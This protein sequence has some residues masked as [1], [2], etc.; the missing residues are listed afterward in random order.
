MF[1]HTFGCSRQVCTA[2]GR[3]LR[4][5]PSAALAPTAR[6]PGLLPPSPLAAPP[7]IRRNARWAG[8]GAFRGL[9]PSPAARK[10]HARMVHDARLLQRLCR[11][12]V[13]M[14]SGNVAVAHGWHA[15]RRTTS[16]GHVSAI[17]MSAQSVQL[18]PLT[19]QLRKVLTQ[20]IGPSL[21]Q[22]QPSADPSSPDGGFACLRA[23][24]CQALPGRHSAGA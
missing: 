18:V 21:L 7:P 10:V 3:V 4:V 16:P 12:T 9:Q 1:L 22:T 17:H 11:A 23:C 2:R 19:T 24:H 5:S 8:H 6:P 20:A 15:R 13:G 14:H